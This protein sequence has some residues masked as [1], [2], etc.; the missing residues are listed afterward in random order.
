MF[1]ALRLVLRVI[2]EVDQGIVPL[3]RLHDDVATVAAIATGRAASGH[4]LLAPEGHAAI[5]AVARLDPNFGFVN[6]HKSAF[7]Q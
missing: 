7:H 2:A 5:P 3:R 4:K 6:E 1:T